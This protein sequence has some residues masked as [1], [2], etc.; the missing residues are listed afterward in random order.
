MRNE[1][2]EAKIARLQGHKKV[3]LTKGGELNPGEIAWLKHIEE[4][5]EE[6][7]VNSKDN[8]I[9]KAA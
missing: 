2:T 9:S 6:C 8:D 4:Q 1:T 3:L 7:R 5:L